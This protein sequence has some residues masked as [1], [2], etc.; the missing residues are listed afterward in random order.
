MK[1]IK[2]T[3]TT[4]F[5]EKA[6]QVH[7]D[8]YDYSLTIVKNMISPVKIMC[9][10]HGEFSQQPRKHLQ[11]GGC[12]AC[13]RDTMFKANE[14]SKITNVKQTKDEILSM[15][16]LVLKEKEQV[17]F[18][19]SEWDLSKTHFYMGDNFTEAYYK[20][21]L[22]IFNQKFGVIKKETIEAFGDTIQTSVDKFPQSYQKQKSSIKT[23]FEGGLYFHTNM[24][25]DNIKL[26]IIN[27]A[28]SMF[29][30]VIFKE[31]ETDKT[32]GMS[33]EQA[34]NKKLTNNN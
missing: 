20:F 16:N 24:N 32:H 12:P 3:S 15:V 23:I 6:K 27:L 9:P 30:K 7:N 4:D 18:S 13:L 5:F 8:K 10:K 34:K 11:G 14:K 31:K 26:M 29:Y 28:E 22:D 21:V 1:E 25:I 2:K 33:M 19:F 17:G